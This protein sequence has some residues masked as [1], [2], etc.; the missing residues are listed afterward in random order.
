MDIVIK[1]YVFIFIFLCY[2]AKS[3][4]FKEQLRLTLIKKIISAID[5]NNFIF[6]FMSKIDSTTWFYYYEL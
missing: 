6:S 2:V 1:K 4:Q 3:K 5:I